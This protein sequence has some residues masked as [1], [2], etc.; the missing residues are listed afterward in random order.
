MRRWLRGFRPKAVG[1]RNFS[2]D[3]FQ[4]F[5]GLDPLLDEAEGGSVLDI[6]SNEGLISYEFAKAGARTLHGFE[7]DRDRVLFARRLFR[8]VP[9]QS[10]FDTANMAVS[11]S[12]FAKAHGDVLLPKYDIVLFLGV[13]HHLIGQTPRENVDDLVVSLLDRAETW[14]AVRTN[15]LDDFE[16][17]ITNH[18]FERTHETPSNGTVGLL[19]LY[20]RV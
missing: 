7:R 16:S 10:H 4:R 1:K 20:R 5:I 9:A 17:V 18:N 12:D 6:G 14:F 15:M 13:Y 19:R 11:G 3:L 2:G 8:D